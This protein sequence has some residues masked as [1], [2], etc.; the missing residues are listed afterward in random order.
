VKTSWQPWRR[1]SRSLTSA[2]N[3]VALK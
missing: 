3:E 2:L 1:S